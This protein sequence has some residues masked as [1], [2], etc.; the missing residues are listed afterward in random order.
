MVCSGGALYMIIKTRKVAHLH[1]KRRWRAAK[2]FGDLDDQRIAHVN[3][4]ERDLAIEV[5]SYD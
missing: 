3:L 2:P 4:A 5:E 1:G